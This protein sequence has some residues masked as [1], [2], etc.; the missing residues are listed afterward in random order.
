MNKNTK[1]MVNPNIFREFTVSFENIGINPARRAENNDIF[2]FLTN[3]VE[4]AYKI[5]GSKEAMKLENI[6]REIIPGKI[7]ENPANR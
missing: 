2:L 1:I 5:I 6:F 7:N 4:I 3:C